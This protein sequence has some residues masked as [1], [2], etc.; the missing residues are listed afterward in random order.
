MIA[1]IDCNI[2]ITLTING[3]LDFISGLFG[4]NIIVASCDDLK[5]EIT[6]VLNRTKFKRYI[7]DSEILKVIEL[8]N[9]V[10]PR[11]RKRPRLCAA[12]R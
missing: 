11:S 10:T 4:N 12:D 7:G 6:M 8:H 3:Q 5:G 1:V 2:W 9:L